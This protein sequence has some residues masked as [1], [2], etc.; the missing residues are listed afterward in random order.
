M[1]GALVPVMVLYPDSVDYSLIGTDFTI[2]QTFIES[3]TPSPEVVLTAA[4]QMIE[5]LFG[6]TATYD[7]STGKV[8]L[9]VSNVARDKAEAYLDALRASIKF[10]KI[11]Q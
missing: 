9:T 8:S 6:G 4:K 5:G 7:K 3:G 2:I 1:A 11:I 10:A